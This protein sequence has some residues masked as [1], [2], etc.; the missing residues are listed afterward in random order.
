MFGR[1]STSSPGVASIAAR[2]SAVDGF[3]V[4][5]PSIT[6]AAPKLSNRRRLPA[7]GTTA[8][9]PVSSVRPGSGHGA[10]EQPLLALLGLPVHVRDL[11]ALDVADGRC[12]ARARAPGSSVWTC[13]LSALGSPTTSSESPS[14]SSSR[15]ELRRRRAP[16][17][18]RR[19]RCSSGTRESSWWTAS[20]PASCASS[21]G[22]SGIGSPASRG[23]DAAD[24]LEQAGA[25]RVDDAGLLQHGE[26]LGRPGERVLAARDERLAGSSAGVER[27]VRAVLGLLGQLA[28]HGQHRPLDRP[29]HGAVGGVARAAER[30]ARP[31]ARRP[32]PAR[33]AP[34]RRR[35][36]SAR[37]SRPSCRAR[38]SARRASAP[39][40]ALRG[41]PPVD[42]SSASTIARAGQRQVRAGVAV[43]HGIDVEVV[44]PAPVRLERLRAPPARARA[45]ARA[46]RHADRRTSSMCT[47]TAA[48]VRPVSRSTSYA[49]R[50]RTVAATSA[51]LRPYS[52]TTWRSMARARRASPRP[53]FP[54]SACRGQQPLQRPLPAI[55][56]TP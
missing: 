43:G 29:P 54:A 23:R 39:S 16:R 48:T 55:P 7:P 3:I 42:A 4:W 30:A 52:T 14:G 13:T 56:T 2:M 50:E 8:T 31:V 20:T 32:R 21:A 10:R 22:A 26:L 6:R 44:D 33:R 47:S 38:P 17:P 46:S 5:P 35:A 12:R 15:L 1:T 40:R 51:R 34:R 28:D 53:R 45:R 27:R 25:A 9:T 36:R 18:R 19:R 11:D 37:R 41:R 24:D 49:T